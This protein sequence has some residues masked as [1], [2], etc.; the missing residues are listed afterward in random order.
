MWCC[1]TTTTTATT[2]IT[3][4]KLAL[5]CNLLLQMLLASRKT[6]CFL[7]LLGVVCCLGRLN[8]NKVSGH[9]L[10]VCKRGAARLR[11]LWLLLLLLWLLLTCSA[12]VCFGSLCCAR[13]ALGAALA[14]AR[15]P[16]VAASCTGVAAELL[17]RRWPLASVSVGLSSS[18]AL[19][20]ALRCSGSAGNTHWLV[21]LRLVRSPSSLSWRV[22]LR[23]VCLLR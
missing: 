19:G 21:C 7:Q 15:A 12:L 18:L 3:A 17:R 1:T 14:V 2:M 6:C 22:A 11:E 20:C 16:I 13:F 9:L 23:V 10:L 8:G 4:T 5:G